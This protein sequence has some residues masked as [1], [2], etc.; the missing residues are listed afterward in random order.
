M[1]RDTANVGLP[2]VQDDTTETCAGG[3]GR[4]RVYVALGDEVHVDVAGLGED[5]GELGADG[6]ADVL[7]VD[8]KLVCVVG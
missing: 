1:V 2:C 7:D 4:E 8:G 6:K 3:H 5:E